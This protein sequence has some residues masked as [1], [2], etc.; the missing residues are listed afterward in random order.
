MIF[1]KKLLAFL[2][3][4]IFAIEP[5]FWEQ[6]Q[7]NYLDL[8]YLSF[9]FAVLF[10]SI[11]K[12]YIPASL[13]LGCFT[14]T[15]FPPTSILVALSIFL[16]ILTQNRKDIF[17]LLFSFILWPAVFVVSYLRFFMLG[18][19]V[20]EFLKVLK[21]F[22]HYYQ[23]GVK[24]QDHLMVFDML[25]RGQW[26]TWWNGVIPVAEW[27]IIWPIAIILT[28]ISLFMWRK[29]IKS[30]IMLVLCWIFFYFL[31]LMVI[32]VTPRYLL[33]LMPFLY[34]VS[35]WVLS[36]SINTKSFRRLR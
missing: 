29:V 4:F 20:I 15:K 36:E 5:L 11:R 24:S 12:Q 31:F 1:K 23:I 35:V 10:F 3:V 30:P 34:N 7:A 22:I 8:L 32:P 6:L 9:L 25:F 33:L 26:P 18:N 2:P 28:V 27:N 19:G 17:K 21:Y 16:Y 13:A 14:A